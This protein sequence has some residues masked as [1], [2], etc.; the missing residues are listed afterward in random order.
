MAQIIY[1][2]V[3]LNLP[4]D[5]YDQL[6]LIGLQKIKDDKDALVNYAAVLL[7]R[8]YLDS[9]KTDPEE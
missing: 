3:E 6:A 5:V 4:Q 9:K 2:E 7:L 1:E 8:E